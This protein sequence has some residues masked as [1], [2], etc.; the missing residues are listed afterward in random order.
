LGAILFIR[1]RNLIKGGELKMREETVLH[2]ATLCFLVKDKKV[3]L[4]IKAKKIGQGCWNG[5]G[6]GIEKGESPLKA[7][8]REL[9]EEAGVKAL[10]KSFEKAA[11]VNCHNTK[12]N[13]DTFVCKVHV[14]LVKQW[15][16]EIKETDEMLKPTWFDISN[17]PFERMMPAD[18]EWLPIALANKKIIVKL[19][20][21]AFQK[22]SL[23]SAEIEYVDSFSED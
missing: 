14:Y 21:G 19:Q 17:L 8:V 23:G 10:P 16:G 4:G 6:G 2:N 11:I 20:L 13:G 9:E 12:S 1:Y 5:F 3:L 7:A 15:S 18:K 22:E